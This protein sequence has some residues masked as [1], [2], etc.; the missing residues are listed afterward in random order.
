MWRSG[1][2]VGGTGWTWITSVGRGR[3]SSTWS[4]SATGVSPISRASPPTRSSPA[5]ADGS[6]G[7]ARATG[8]AGTAEA[9]APIVDTPEGLAALFAPEVSPSR[10]PTAIFAYSD[11]HAILAFDI[12]AGLGLRVPDDV[13]LVG[14]NNDVRA[15]SLRPA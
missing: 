14:F 10:R 4:R 2:A 13:S 15:A 11:G 5:S 1:P 12:L 6:R 3:R 8:A 7:S 9:D